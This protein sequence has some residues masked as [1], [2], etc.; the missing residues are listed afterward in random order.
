MQ[1][2][3]REQFWLRALS[4]LLGLALCSLAISPQE[5]LNQEVTVTAIEVPVRVFLK[6]QIVK[7]LTKED[8]EIYENGA[9]QEISG[10]EI[11]SRRI[12]G[13]AE[14]TAVETGIP[15]P[16]LFILIFDIFDYTDAL[17]E[18][19]DYFFQNIYKPKD[20][21]VIVTESRLIDIEKSRS[22][23]DTVRSL[24]KTL[25]NFKIV[26][27]K[28]ILRAYDQL[29]EEGDRL[30]S[31]LREE[32]NLSA[33]WDQPIV[34]FYDNYFR[35]WDLYRQQFLIPDVA[36]Y[37][38]L[39]KTLHSI[40]AE[41]WAICFQ[42]REL[43]PELRNEGPLDRAI[44]EL[45]ERPWEDPLD[46]AKARTIQNKR[47]E[48][49]KAFDLARDFPADLL[50]DLFTESGITF[51]FIL[52]R[53]LKVI[54][55]EDFNL[56]EVTSD[57]EEC[58]RKIS[59]S[60]G[61]YLTFS[62]DALVALKDASEKEDYH[63]LLV[64]QSK[65]PLEKRGDNIEVKVQR[66]DVQVFNLK[67]YVNLAGRAVTIADVEATLGTLRFTLKN[68]AMAKTENGTRGIAEVNVSLFNA[69]SKKVFSEGKT[70]DLV[71]RE[72][73]FTLNLG[74]LGPG[75]Y[76]LIIDAL[77]KITNEKCV[78]SRMIEL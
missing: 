1:T 64:Y 75:P 54:V 12:S 50:K 57:Y 16:R 7:G 32:K 77:D 18:A 2:E 4:L 23:D 59:R 47:W 67:H 63:Y 35:V 30:L 49:Q 78:F 52:M 19:I 71:K 22:I 46:R 29:R 13:G 68:Y 69:E 70:L 45:V 56:R 65:A 39:I 42:Q 76:F 15:R 28:N 53:S 40:S 66:N 62:N 27:T 41:K 25:K 72:A 51:H 9:K 11:V 61:G 33:F 24:K 34:R 31:D 48:L 17:G 5:K 21:L 14:P 55:S 58:F 60:T 8:F 37:Q 44:S 3:K 20:Q 36:L 26:S 10:F 6:N 73:R 43:F 74:R 38:G